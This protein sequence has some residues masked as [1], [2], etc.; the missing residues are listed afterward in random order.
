MYVDYEMATTVTQQHHQL[1]A[2]MTH[3]PPLCVAI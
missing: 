1:L 2:S 3:G